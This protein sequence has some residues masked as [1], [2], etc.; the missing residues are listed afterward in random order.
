MGFA[1]LGIGVGGAA[2]PLISYRLPQAFGCRSALEA[3]GVLIIVLS[4]LMVPLLKENPRRVSTKANRTRSNPSA[5]SSGIRVLS[6]G[7]G[8][9]VFDCR[10]WRC[11]P[12]LEIVPQ[13]RS[14]L[15]R[16]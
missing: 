9:H 2:V 8:K 1:Y 3:L 14:T 16:R 13:P 15:P 4:L 6:A 7:A 5:M 12:A 10:G 11:E